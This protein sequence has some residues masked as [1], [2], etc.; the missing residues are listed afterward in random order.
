MA[1]HKVKN[2]EY[3]LLPSFLYFKFYTS[4]VSVFGEEA[5]NIIYALFKNAGQDLGKN[6]Y[7]SKILDPTSYL[8]KLG[9]GKII[10]QRYSKKIEIKVKESP[11][12]G[13]FKD[14]KYRKKVDFHL[15]GFFAGLFS[16]LYQKNYDCEEKVCFLENLDSCTFEC[17]KNKNDS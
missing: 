11:H 6:L 12:H 16:E 10:V 14:K 9:W 3:F 5:K 8:N 4:S 7:N 13:P 15:S 17:R 2:C 1:P